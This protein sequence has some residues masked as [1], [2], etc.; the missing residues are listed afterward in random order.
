VVTV[1]AAAEMSELSAEILRKVLA[2]V[3]GC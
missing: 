3:G 1:D 2:V